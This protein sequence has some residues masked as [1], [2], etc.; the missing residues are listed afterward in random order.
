MKLYEQK[1]ITNHK[2]MIN[3]DNYLGTY[4]DNY[5][6]YG[7]EFLSE[8]HAS[9]DT[10]MEW[11]KLCRENTRTPDRMIVIDLTIVGFGLAK[12]GNNSDEIAK[13]LQL[14][15]CT[16]DK[17]IEDAMVL[18]NKFWFKQE[19]KANKKIKRLA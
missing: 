1:K 13:C 14:Y 15:Y 17:A 7:V 9:Y 6:K 8:L 12:S 19:I 18:V 3:D 11:V 5:V 4:F 2:D 10:I 16:D